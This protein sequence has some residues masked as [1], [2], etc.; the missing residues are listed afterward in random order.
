MCPVYV[1]F[2]SQNLPK[3]FSWNER[4]KENQSKKIC[5][6]SCCLD[7]CERNS[8][9][10]TSQ[11]TRLSFA[12]DTFVA[13]D[14]REGDNIYILQMSSS[15]ALDLIKTVASNDLE[16]LGSVRPFESEW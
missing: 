16:I 1:Y 12:V 2:A 5:Y 14:V 6:S 13:A 4:R 9:N 15:C 8:S 10:N 3:S 7:N 11:A